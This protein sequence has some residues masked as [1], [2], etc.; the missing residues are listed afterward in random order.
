M[1]TGFGIYHKLSFLGF[2]CGC[3]WQKGEQNAS[4]FALIDLLGKSSR[5]SAGASLTS[6]TSLL[7]FSLFMGPVL[8]LHSVATSLMRNFDL[9][10]TKRWTFIFS[11]V[12]LTL[13]CFCESYPANWSEHFLCPSQKSLQIPA[14]PCPVIRNSTVAHFSQ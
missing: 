9:Y 14:A 4:L 11:S 13:R 7:S 5:V 10:S 2:Y 12:R 1:H 3:G 6:R 8:K